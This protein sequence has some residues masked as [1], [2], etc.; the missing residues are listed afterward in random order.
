MNN[1]CISNITKK[2]RGR[3]VLDSISI[4][5]NP[6]IYALLG[7][8]GAGKT[9]LL[10]CLTGALGPQSGSIV[11]NYG[12][13]RSGQSLIGYLP[14]KFGLYAE[15]TVYESL[16]LFAGLKKIENNVSDEIDRVI[17]AVNLSE[18]RNKRVRKLSGGMLRRVGIAQA[19]LGN[20]EIIV[21]DEPTTGLDPNER[22]R[23]KKLILD[24]PK[25]KIVIVST[26]IVSDIES[27]CDK[28]IVLDD[29]TV[30]FFGTIEELEKI[31][32]D[33]HKMFSEECKELSPL[34]AGYLW[35][36]KE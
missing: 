36:S 19:L 4:T 20:P 33:S 8:N 16:V 6:G 34:E 3:K 7:P 28:V 17:S 14:Q 1:V 15:L 30:G 23:F 9:T 2:F 22:M 13:N 29:A 31:G 24:L 5:L 21:L 27:M 35:V 32:L 25:D 10:R 26:H 12:D 18:E 11:I